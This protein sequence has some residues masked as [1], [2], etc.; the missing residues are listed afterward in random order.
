MDFKGDL[1]NRSVAEILATLAQSGQ[2]GK[3]RLSRRDGEAAVLFDQG[4]INYASTRDGRET[5]GSILIARRTITPRQLEGALDL[6]R[7]LGTGSLGSIL[8]DLNMVS[9]DEVREAVR[10]QIS[11]VLTG[12]I[13]W[14]SGHY[15]FQP[16]P[17]ALTEYTSLPLSELLPESIGSVATVDEPPPRPD[18]LPDVSPDDEP[19]PSASADHLDLLKQ[20]SAS[21]QS[22][23][24][25]GELVT[26]V[27]EAAHRSFDRAVLFRLRPDGFQGISQIGVEDLDS[28]ANHRFRRLVISVDEPSILSAATDEHAPVLRPLEDHGGDRLLANELG[29]ASPSESVAIPMTT[30][31]RVLALLYADN[32]TSGRPIEGTADLELTVMEVG[33]SMEK[34]L[35]H[36]RREH[37]DNLRSFSIPAIGAE[38]HS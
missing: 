6:Q 12:L 26:Q 18:P 25:T 11:Q 23:A 20:I 29:G 34:S 27:L 38:F 15:E 35:L 14:Q 1:T 24:L 10:E 17:L 28:D 8:V 22:P 21:I 30:S 7:S 37:Y 9:R 4:R 3:L 16:L 19:A 33:M 36:K 32:A 2:S 5:F 13:T 31:G